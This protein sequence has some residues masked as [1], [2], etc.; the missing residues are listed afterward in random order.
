VSSSLPRLRPCVMEKIT[1]KDGTT[2]AFVTNGFGP[3]IVFVGGAFNDHTRLAPLAAALEEDHT[4]VTYDR[5]ARGQSGDGPAYAVER[6][7]ED[8]AAVIETV[9]GGRAVVFGYSS[10]AVLALHAVALGLPIDQLFLFEGP[11]GRGVADLPARMQKLVDDQR[12]GDAVALFQAEGIGLPPEVIEQIRRS[13]MWPGLVALAQ[14][15]V[16]DAT[17]AMVKPDVVTVPTLVMTGA[18]TSPA[19]KESAKLIVGADHVQVA[20][21]VGH[22]IPVDETARLIRTV[23][24]P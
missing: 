20:G 23:K 12:P 18:A 22:D 7:V 4:V 16:Y 21:G 11:F 1:S 2:I 13:P 15:A 3:A 19:L 10:G 8:L 9:A 5:R 6:E 17:I 24:K 14:S